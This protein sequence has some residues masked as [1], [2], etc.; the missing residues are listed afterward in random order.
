MKHLKKKR[1]ILV[2]QECFLPC[3]NAPVHTAAIIQD[4]LTGHSIQ[5][6]SPAASRLLLV[7]AVKGQ[8]SGFRP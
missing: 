1:P 3:D 4:W 5:V 7:S 6:S 2:E 8:A